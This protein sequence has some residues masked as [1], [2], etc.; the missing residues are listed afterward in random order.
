MR[1][2]VANMMLNEVC[3]KC[4]LTKKAV[5]YYVEQGL[6]APKVQE[7]GYRSFSDADAERLKRIS[8]LRR[9]GLSVAE[10]R[11]VLQGAAELTQIAGR[12]SWEIAALQEKQTLLQELARSGDWER[13]EA[14]LEQLEKRQSLLM[15][16]LD[17]FPGSYGRYICA[18]FA[19]YL[20]EPI[21]TE[22]QMEAYRTVV[23][24]LDGVV[25]EWPDGLQGELDEISAGFDERFAA[26]VT[27]DMNRAAQD[28]ES[29]L[30]ESREAIERY[31]TWKQ[32]EEYKET[33]AHRLEE[34]LRRFAATSGYNDVFLPAMCRLS[35][36]YRDYQL[37]LKR[38]D[39]TLL[40]EYPQFAQ[41]K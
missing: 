12:K 11:A 27:A 20:A 36:S 4:A 7:N 31:I 41:E 16:L 32:S 25:F 9:L 38:A 28:M 19:A 13:T 3:R 40:Q 8:M 15:R 14:Q 39:A 2:E 24:F 23:D 1:L 6:I 10:I 30:Q 21:E 5:E 37:A 22:E 34:A 26:E 29:Y 33:P 17:A 35:R 18:H